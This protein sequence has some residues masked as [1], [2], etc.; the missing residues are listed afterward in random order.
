MKTPT[1]APADKTGPKKFSEK[2]DAFIRA[3]RVV[4]LVVLAVLVA[5]VAFIAVY[6]AVGTATMNASTA[7]IE[8]LTGDFD[9]WSSDTDAAKKADAEKAL[10]ADLNGVI[11]KWPRQFA[12][13]RAYAMLARISQANKDWD[14]AEKNWVAI[15]DRFPKT[16]IAPLAL[17]N[18]AA[19]AEERGANDAASAYYK[20]VVDKYTGKSVGLPHALFAIGRLAEGSNDYPAALSSYEKLVA[21]YP[22][23]D[24]TKLAEDRIISI[25]AKGLAK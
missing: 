19:A 9:A 1:K 18:A 13:A 2:L 5:G 25:K 14:G 6:S 16:F 17:I 24:W 23:D 20:K 11:R 12:S 10:V 7:R 22:G 3:N 15:A 4:L 21:Q 8:K